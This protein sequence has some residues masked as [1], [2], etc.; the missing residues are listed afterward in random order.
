MQA[1]LIKNV[2]LKAKEFRKTPLLSKISYLFFKIICF[3]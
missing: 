2:M 3:K 1:K